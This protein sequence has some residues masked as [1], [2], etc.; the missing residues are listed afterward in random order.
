MTNPDEYTALP[1][2]TRRA[3]LHQALAE[4]GALC[5]ICGLPIKPGDESLD[6]KTPRSKGGSN[7]LDNL[8]P[9]HKRCNSAKG[10]KE[11]DEPTA[12]IHNGM[13]LWNEHNRHDIGRH[14]EP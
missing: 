12:I 3:M 8:R 7:T 10:N 13:E 9:A 1:Y 6:H 11:R 5:Y 4:Y 2:T 14:K